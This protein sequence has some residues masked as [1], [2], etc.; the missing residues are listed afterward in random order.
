MSRPEHGCAP[1]TDATGRGAG[2]VT[3]ESDPAIVAD[4]DRKRTARLQAE[5][6]QHGIALHRLADGAWLAC[7]WNL[8]REV[9]D[10]AIESWLQTVTGGAA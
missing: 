4:A 8:S 6:A 5:A 7:R 9:A 3:G 10:S 1:D 2:G